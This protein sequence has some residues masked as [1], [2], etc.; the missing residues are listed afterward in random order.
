M[1]GTAR[2]WD[3]VTGRELLTLEGHSGPFRSV[4]VLPGG[5]LITQSA[6]G[7]VKLW[8]AASPEQVTVGGRR[9][10]FAAHRPV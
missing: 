10:P 7:T 6:D 2:L 1:D 9:G 4:A 8:E 5:R 3:A